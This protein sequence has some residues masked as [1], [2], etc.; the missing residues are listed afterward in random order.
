MCDGDG[1]IVRVAK[2]VLEMILPRARAPAIA[3]TSI[4]EDCEVAFVR[5]GISAGV[6]PP[7]HD[8][9]HS[10]VRGVVMGPRK[11]GCPVGQEV[12]DAIGDEGPG[13]QGREVVVVDRAF[14]VS[15]RGTIIPEASNFLFLFRVNADE[16]CARASAIL[17][18]RSDVLELLIALLWRS[19]TVG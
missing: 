1:Q 6:A 11:D 12:M 3:P 15:P 13:C 17:S 10:K 8:T 7:F 16:R 9:F 4:S 19:R 14:F 2:L 5:I 18:N